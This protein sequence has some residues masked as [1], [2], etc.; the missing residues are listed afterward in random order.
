MSI[1]HNE[2]SGTEAVMCNRSLYRVV[3]LCQSMESVHIL[4]LTF[5]T[6]CARTIPTLVKHLLRHQDLGRYE[7]GMIRV[8]EGFTGH[9]RGSDTHKVVF[10]YNIGVLKS[11][12]LN[13][14]IFS[15][16]TVL[17]TFVLI[18]LKLIFLVQ[19]FPLCYSY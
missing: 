9:L 8:L 4:L 7:K 5:L 10:Q 18:A 3:H 19:V 13:C 6:Y 1:K 14:P 11:L 16:Y 12:I 15:A 17:C 2:K